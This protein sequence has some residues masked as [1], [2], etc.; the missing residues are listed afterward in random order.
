MGKEYTIYIDSE[1]GTKLTAA[2]GGNTTITTVRYNFDWNIMPQGEYEMSFTFLSGLVKQEVA[3]GDNILNAMVVEAVVPFSS[4]RYQV[5]PAASNGYAGTSNVIGFIKTQNVDKWTDSGSHFSM[6]YW[7]SQ[8]DNPTLKLY[9]S[10]TGN[11]FVIKLRAHTGDIVTSTP[12]N[13]NMILKL[14]HIC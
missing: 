11:E 7:C 13:Y 10:P 1:N 6:R 9:G 2:D 14:K 3:A 5:A 8:V 12:I 4:D